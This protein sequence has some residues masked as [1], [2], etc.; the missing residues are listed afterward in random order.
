VQNADSLSTARASVQALI[1][2]IKADIG[3]RRAV[4]ADVDKQINQLKTDP[5]PLDGRLG[6][7]SPP[8]PASA[9][10]G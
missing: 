9:R 3:A 6:A 10:R 1:E 2:S 8:S 5:L 7:S 4:L